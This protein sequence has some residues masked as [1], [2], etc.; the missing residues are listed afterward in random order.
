MMRAGAGAEAAV[1]NAVGN[2]GNAVENVMGEA[3]KFGEQALGALGGEQAMAN[4]KVALC[5]TIL[6]VII[7]MFLPNVLP[8]NNDDPDNF[9]NGLNAVLSAHKENLLPSVVVVVVC[10]VVGGLIASKF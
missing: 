10:V 6:I 5:A 4:L 2:A 3:G 9:V 8:K 7:A 1:G